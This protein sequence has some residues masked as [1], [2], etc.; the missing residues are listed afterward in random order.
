MSKIA[1]YGFVTPVAGVVLSMII[2]GESSIVGWIYIP[3]LLLV[4]LSIIVVNH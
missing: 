1:V 2:L 3:A 4:S